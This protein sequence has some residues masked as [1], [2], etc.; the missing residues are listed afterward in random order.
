MEDK[1]RPE[2][3]RRGDAASGGLRLKGDL[4]RGIDGRKDLC[5]SCKK[6]ER[7]TEICRER[8]K[9]MFYIYSFL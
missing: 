7:I 5:K 1:I 6:N 8:V 4:A 2:R 3:V 9:L